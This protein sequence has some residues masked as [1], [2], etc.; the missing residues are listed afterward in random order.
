VDE[1]SFVAGEISE[2]KVDASQVSVIVTEGQKVHGFF[3]ESEASEVLVA[4]ETT[5]NQVDLYLISLLEEPGNE[6][7][8]Y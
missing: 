2:F 5:E 1:D 7:F 3:K 4:L 8:D 6:N